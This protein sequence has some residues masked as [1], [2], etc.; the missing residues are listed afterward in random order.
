MVVAL[1]FMK[2]ARSFAV[3]VRRNALTQFHI[4]SF[5]GP[6]A[7]C[8]AGG[9]ATRV[10]G[11]METVSEAG[12][13]TH[14]W[15]VGDPNRPGHEKHGRLTL[16][17]WCQWMSRYHPAGVYDG[18]EAKQRDYAASMPPYLMK[19]ILSP[20]LRRCGRAFVLAEEWHTVHAVLHLDWLLRVSGMRDRVT[21]FWNAN[22]TFA[23]DRI[24]WARLSK[25]AVITTVSRYM[26]Y[27]MRPLGVSPLV[28]PN[29]LSEE[30]L[31]PA[32]P[33]EVEAFHCR[34][35]GRTVLAK[36]ARWDPEKSWINAID[37]IRNL[38]SRGA[39]PLLLARGGLESYGKEVLEAAASRGLKVVE[40]R[41]GRPGTRGLLEGVASL[42]EADVVSI[43]TPVDPACRR[44]LLSGA[45]AVLANSRHEPFGLVGLET[46]AV[47]GL[48]CTGATGEDYAEPG[49]NALVVETDDP[50]EFVNLF[51][52]LQREPRRERGLRKTGRTTAKHYAWPNIVNEVLLPRLRCFDDSSRFQQTA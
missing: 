36:M 10:D 9:L 1:L 31:Q 4:L 33:S 25:A 19:E 41:F 35:Q 38:K 43:R 30:A 29:G 28:I 22:N 50:W 47:E 40:R 3:C 48:A 49:R 45:D 52:E 8:R 23:F 12:Y 26:K 17:R 46:M 21:I 18:E 5:E 32:E 24:D 15:F 13:E 51:H 37:I 34:L 6:D 2:C 11:L 39:N 27:L 7:Y 44:V 20:H 42:E 14:V 16:H